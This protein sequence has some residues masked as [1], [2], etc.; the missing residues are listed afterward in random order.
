MIIDA[1]G[2]LRYDGSSP[3]LG[4]ATEDGSVTLTRDGT[5]GKVVIMINKTGKNG[6]PIVVVT[7]DDTGTSTDRTLTVTIEAADELAFDTTQ[8]VVATFP[9]VTHGASATLMVRRVHTQKKYL[10]SV[11]TLANSNG[12]MAVDFMVF[13]GTGLMN[14]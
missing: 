8:E 12:T 10:R 6:I 5:T 9:V 1:L 4:T 13:I 3:D 2:M 7:D 14:T 11:I